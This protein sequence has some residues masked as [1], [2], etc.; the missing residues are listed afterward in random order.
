ML[1]KVV[2]SLDRGV[3]E[4]VV[5]LC[6][7]IECLF[8]PLLELVHLQVVAHS[9]MSCLLLVLRQLYESVDIV[10]ILSHLVFPGIFLG[11][12]ISLLTKSLRFLN[13][14][15]RVRFQIDVLSCCTCQAE[16]GGERI[17]WGVVPALAFVEQSASV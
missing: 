13:S 6:L 15:E 16:W 3:L 7:F 17:S 1:R 4:C 11:E 8:S 5:F 2:L 14:V 10:A 12:L 9:F